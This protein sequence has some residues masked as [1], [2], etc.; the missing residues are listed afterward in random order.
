MFDGLQSLIL[1]DRKS[2]DDARLPRADESAG[3]KAWEWSTCDDRLTVVM[4]GRQAGKSTTCARDRV[5]RLAISRPGW[6]QLYMTLVRKNTKK[7]FW[8]PVQAR[9][10]ECNARF[11]A[12]QTD[13]RAV[14]WNGSI[15]EA[16]SAD[17]I[18]TIQRVR[19]DNWND[20]YIDEAQAYPD[21]L[22]RELILE[23]IFPLLMTRG[24]RLHLLGTPPDS[25]VTYFVECLKDPKWRWF[26]WTIFDNKYVPRATVQQTID[27]L[28]LEPGSN[29]YQREILGLPVKDPTRLVFEYEEERNGYYEGSIDFLKPE[30]G[31]KFAAGVDLGWQDMTSVHVVGWQ[32]HDP[33]QGV[34]EVFNWAQS[35][36]TLD[37]ITPIL[38]HVRSTYKPRRWIGDRASGGDAIILETLTARMK[39]V[40]ERKPGPGE[41]IESIGIVNT[42]F[43]KG[44]IKLIRGGETAKDCGKVVWS[45]D[46]Q[47][48]RVPNQKG[49]HSDRM[50]SFRYAHHAARHFMAKPP[51]PPL[52]Y[53]EER[54]LRIDAENK[55]GDNGEW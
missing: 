4:T 5:P 7:F 46:A 23:I 43:R 20:V 15:I 42:D 32:P 28:G 11:H 1:R 6:K 54:I 29:Q 44:R 24:G 31:W 9:L 34:Y 3:P 27:D 22:L 41:L 48:K 50:D 39:I 21:P 52:T 53:Q 8:H 18:A 30:G 25:I 12:D 49:F 33:E 45:F 40:F 17:D 36:A 35:N 37:D 51:K 13:M 38:Q 2:G 47:N 19:G 26:N 14:L 16:T 55:R 10:R